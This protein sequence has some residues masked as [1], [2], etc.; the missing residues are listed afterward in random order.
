MKCVTL[1]LALGLL[2]FTVPPTKVGIVYDAV[3]N[4]TST[5]DG[6]AE[7]AKF[8]GVWRFDSYV[9]AGKKMDK[10]ER[11]KTTIK[12]EEGRFTQRKDKVF[13]GAGT[14]KV[15]ATKSPMDFTMTYKEGEATG[16]TL[17]GIYQWDDDDLVVCLGNPRPGKFE[18]DSKNN[19]TLVRLSKVK[20]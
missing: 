7:A 1:V 5:A 15:D 4:C 14:W 2:I 16:V 6:K 18:S 13:D 10:K 3:A 12:F 17:I 8:H 19:N 20:K 9:I 11:E